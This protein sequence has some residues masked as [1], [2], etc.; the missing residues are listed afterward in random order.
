MLDPGPGCA[1]AVLRAGDLCVNSTGAGT[2]G[3]VGLIEESHVAQQRLVADGHV[4]VVRVDPTKMDPRF[5]WY[6]LSTD[7][8]YEQ[9]NVCLGVG[10]TNQTELGRGPL[11]RAAVV[12]PS[13]AE[14]ARIVGFL[15][16]ETTH[17]DE[18][19]AEQRR[20]L[21]LLDE[22]WDALLDE[23]IWGSRDNVDVTPLAGL[24]DPA[25]SL[26]YGVVLAGEHVDDGVPLVEAG[27]V[28]D[29][30][31]RTEPPK[32]TSA[33]VEREYK[34]SR[35]CPGDILMAIR[36][37]VGRVARA[38]P[39]MSGWNLTRDVALI[40]PRLD[41]VASEWLLLAL[42]SP[43]T[44]S[45]LTSGSSGSA[46]KGI[47][48]AALGKL[49]LPV[50]DLATQLAVEG[51]VSSVRKRVDLIIAQVTTQVALLR[52]HRQALI[53]AGVTGGL[54]EVRKVAYA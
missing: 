8:F 14:Q 7:E 41:R 45:L 25:R 10:S 40:A 15:D 16:K 17:I 6:Q 46:I 42:W 30:R 39:E 27:S 33:E 28:L 11:S 54:D 50:P 2:L 48:L 35:V 5:L 26:T 34:R 22:H 29:G 49:R 37:T 38:T 18:L 44:Q 47:N 12:V 36:G 13:L 9:A 19:V 20:L 4:T 21:R 53:T 52:E 23:T 31:F 51:N 24:I 3:R 32:R 1:A 43:R